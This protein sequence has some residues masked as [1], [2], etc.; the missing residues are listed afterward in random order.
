MSVGAQ[1]RASREARGLSIDAVAHTTRVHSRIL[2]AIERD[3]LSAMPPRPFGRGFVSAYAREMGL[4]GDRTTQDY[5]AQFAPAAPAPDATVA[6]PQGT[7]RGSRAWWPLAVVSLG[8]LAGVALAVVAGRPAATTGAAQDG[9]PIAEPASATPQ[10]AASAS[11]AAA[12]V[13]SPAGPA[14]IPATAQAANLTIV[15]TASRRCWV[16]AR[17]DGRR[18]LFTTVV[19]GAAQTLVAAREIVLRVGDA[20]A[21][22]WTINGREPAVMGR[23][24]QVRDVRI[25]PQTAATVR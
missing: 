17:T 6:H 9:A 7:I 8:V 2:A 3:D 12:G 4:D 5:F 13:T 20:G 10:P 1:L 25:T 23:P 18:A 24:G 16:T 11:P 15:L 21:L 19:P 22:T 14:P